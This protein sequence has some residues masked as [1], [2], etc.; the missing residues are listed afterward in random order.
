MRERQGADDDDEQHHEQGRHADLV[1]LLDAA[2]DAAGHD[3]KAD[4]HEGDQHADGRR[5]AGDHRAEG[6]AVRHALEEAKQVDDDVVDAVAAQDR[7]EGH[8]QERREHREPAEPGIL[9][10]H[11]FVSGDRSLS[12]LT[13]EGKLRGH[14]DQADEDRQEQIDE[15]EREAAGFAHLVRKAPDIAEADRRADGCKQEAYVAAPRAALI[16]HRLPSLPY[17]VVELL[18]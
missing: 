2:G 14:D 3:E 1:E 15:Q 7:V 9:A 13:A 6:A 11:R 10:R 5:D 18:T 12:G 16:F 17:I 4:R 8:D